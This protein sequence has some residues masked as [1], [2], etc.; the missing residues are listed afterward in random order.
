MSLSMSISSQLTSIEGT[1]KNLVYALNQLYNS[2]SSPF[3]NGWSGNGGD[4][5][6]ELW[7]GVACAG[8]NVTILGL[9]GLGLTGDLGSALENLTTLI[10]LD[11]SNN[12]LSGVLPLQLPPHVQEIDL[13]I[14][15][16]TGNI[17]TSF[18]ELM[19]LNKLNIS[20][21]LLSGS[22][23]DMFSSMQGLTVLDLS[24]NALDG[25]LPSSLSTLTS[26]SSLYLQDNSLTGTINLLAELPLTDLDVSNNSFT[27]WIPSELKKFSPSKF[28]G[29][30]FNTFPAPPPPPPSVPTPPPPKQIKQNATVS[31]P[32]DS[33]RRAPGYHL[34]VSKWIG[35][36]AAAL[37]TVALVVIIILFFISRRKERDENGKF[38]S[39][40]SWRGTINPPWKEN[41]G[42]SYIL[43]QDQKDL[44]EPIVKSPPGIHV[45]ELTE[46]K[47]PP[48]PGFLMEESSK[49]IIENPT[50]ELEQMKPV[51]LSPSRTNNMA[52][53]A[54]LRPP[55]V[56]EFL[57][58]DKS[59]EPNGRARIRGT[60]SSIAAHAYNIADLQLATQS[61]SEENFIGNGTLGKVYKGQ[62]LNGQVIA[63]KKLD[64]SVTR[65]EQADFLNFV[66]KISRF[67]HKNVVELIGYCVELGEHLLVYE[68]ISNGSLYE[69][70]HTEMENKTRLN[71]E[72]RVRIALG[73]ARAL[74]YLQETCRPPIF[75][76][77]LTSINILLDDELIPHLSDCGLSNYLQHEQTSAERLG[78]S[79]PEHISSGIY[80]IESD[81]YSFGLVMLELLTGRKVLDSSR[82]RSEQSLV[83]WA[84]PQ[85][86]DIDALASMLDPSIDGSFSKKS[87]SRFADVISQ[88]VQADPNFR[89]SMGEIVQC[90]EQLQEV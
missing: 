48:I 4:P 89:P 20:N 74:E 5:C 61:F 31:S 9:S 90:L 69:K 11:L 27:G 12:L 37:L 25:I 45:S 46:L 75:H 81:I 30:L 19:N 17:P 49:S 53:F 52:D 65:I 6:V 18:A 60:K 3:L 32:S 47:P 84:A 43:A 51:I 15:Q 86:C 59:R 14:N 76:R 34:T 55:P 1:S 73:T 36:G 58:V 67:R 62:L 83:R 80:T 66:S 50:E 63:V 2:L 24:S 70:L 71:W 29:N 54:E 28:A 7:E 78:Y 87:M 33:Q 57:K 38:D 44:L 16:F 23:P 64:Y 79:A 22:L 42:Q 40:H 88:C 85:L 26:L 39:E 21:N 41:K 82:P 56:P 8:P 13:S 35:I 77:N 10:V 68:F 72:A